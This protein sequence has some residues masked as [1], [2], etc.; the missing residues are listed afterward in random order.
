MLNLFS[1]QSFMPS[2]NLLILHVDSVILL[3][4]ADDLVCF[5]LLLV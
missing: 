1:E 2:R 4:L 5:V 3:Q